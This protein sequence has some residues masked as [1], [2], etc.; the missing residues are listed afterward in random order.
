MNAEFFFL[1]VLWIAAVLLFLAAPIIT[2]VV[3]LRLRKQSTRQ[4]TEILEH[5]QREQSRTRQKISELAQQ[6]AGPVPEA[7]PPLVQEAEV[8]APPFLEPQLAVLSTPEPT[9][10]P[11][12]ASPAPVVP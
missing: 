6:L 8:P 7:E 5:V 1:I 12:R 3:V 10:A 9:P 4:F 2:L 11:E